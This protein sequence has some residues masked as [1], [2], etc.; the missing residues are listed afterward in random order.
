MKKSYFRHDIEGLRGI[1]V[2]AVIIFHIQEALLPGGFV[3]VDIFFVISG[4][5]IS[6]QLYKEIYTDNFSLL[7]FYRRRVKRIMPAMLV[8]ITITTI[9]AQIILRPTEAERVAESAAFSALSLANV[10]FWLFQD[11]SY[12][13]PSSNELP[14][15]HLW[16]LGVEE[17]FYIFWPLILMISASMIPKI[18][19]LS[20]ILILIVF[21]S[22]LSEWLYPYSPSFTYYMLPTRMGELLIGAVA[23]WLS[24]FGVNKVSSLLLWFKRWSLYLGWLGFGL[25]CASLF[26]LDENDVFPGINA[27]YPTLGA[28]LLIVSGQYQIHG[29]SRLLTIPPLTFCGR[30]SYSAY[31]WHWPLLAFYRYAERDINLVSGISLF[32]VTLLF[33]WLSFR[34][35]ETPFR[36]N[37]DNAWVVIIKLYALPAFVILV[38]C[39]I[40]MKLDG[41]GHRAFDSSFTAKLH[42]L[43][44]KNKAPFM[45]D[46]VCQRS[47]LTTNDL[48]NS[49]CIIGSP[50][51]RKA[52]AILWG[53]SNAAHYI[54]VIGA[55]SEKIGFSFKNIEIGSCPPLLMD[56]KKYVT[57]KRYQ[58]CKLSL[59]LGWK[60]VNKY[61]VIFL[62]ANWT[63]Y[64]EKSEHFI[65]DLNATIKELLINGKQV[66][67][68][69]KIPV[70]LRFDRRCQEKS[71]S[72]PFM[73]CNIDNI[74]ISSDILK[75]NH[76][77]QQKARNTSNLFYFDINTLLC[78][79]GQC[80]AYD[81]HGKILYYDQSHLNIDASWQL[82]KEFLKNNST[83]L[84]DGEHKYLDLD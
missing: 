20:T 51:N 7:E 79:H 65:H 49:N 23:A 32:L 19:W 50:H 34:Y 61:K 37:K 10:Y 67:L 82:G 68:I 66:V 69:G 24:Q 46:Y 11:V 5:L 56:P 40:F 72:L 4:Y 59:Q 54:G 62:A 55:I 60:E 33:G 42:Q 48:T 58:D 29:L 64:Q 25:I 63:V 2:L 15:L 8:L 14:F 45:E 28:F 57:A 77:L 17:Q 52:N 75:M 36:N 84:F 53:D 71:L 78:E 39:G 22:L 76:Q 30:I 73:N 18:R 21:S 83:D 3:G 16:S 1:A 41:F 81:K 6:Q 12:F 43:K 27:I 47:K 31:L 70:F 9:V 80:S 44:Q 13:A 74:E 38:F 35:V 26:I